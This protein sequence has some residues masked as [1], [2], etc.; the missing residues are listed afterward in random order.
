MPCRPS[1]PAAWTRPGRVITV[2]TIEGGTKDN[3]ITG[4]VTMTGTIRTFEP[5][6]CGRP[7]LS[8]WSEP[9]AWPA[10]WAGILS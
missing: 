9:A 2:G 1:S 7:S 6:D 4:K 5:E 10:P 8:R 3:I